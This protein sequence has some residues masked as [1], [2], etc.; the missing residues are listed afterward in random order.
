MAAV[1][2]E[3]VAPSQTTREVGCVVIT[4]G[5]FSVTL[6]SLLVLFASR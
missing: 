3:V 2:N 4:K 5:G 6:S 1:F